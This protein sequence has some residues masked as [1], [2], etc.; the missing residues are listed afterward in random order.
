MIAS[1]FANSGP[2]AQP[3]SPRTASEDSSELSQDRSDSGRV[4][5]DSPS[6]SISAGSSLEDSIS[7]TFMDLLVESGPECYKPLDYGIFPSFDDFTNEFYHQTLPIA[8]FGDE[9]FDDLSE[10]FLW[11]Y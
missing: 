1:Q 7:G 10:F 11:N 3:P 2:T 5:P 6:H 4:S 9:K 8:E